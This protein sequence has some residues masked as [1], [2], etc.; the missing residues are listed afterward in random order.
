[1]LQ[2]DSPELRGYSCSHST[3]AEVASA[4]VEGPLET[5]LLVLLRAGEAFRRWSGW[6]PRSC[7]ERSSFGFEGSLLFLGTCKKVSSCPISIMNVPDFEWGKGWGALG[8]MRQIK[9]PW[10]HREPT[11]ECEERIIVIILHFNGRVQLSNEESQA[12][13]PSPYFPWVFSILLP[14]C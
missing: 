5:E 9:M 4:G 11:F 13:F 10:E 3:L 6:L 8:W 2:L 7:L 1:M 14:T 12:A